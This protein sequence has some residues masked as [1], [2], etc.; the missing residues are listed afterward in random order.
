MIHQ[1]NANLQLDA[2][3]RELLASCQNMLQQHPCSTLEIWLEHEQNGYTASSILPGYRSISCHHQGLF[4][5]HTGHPRRLETIRFG[6]L[7][8]RDR[9]QVQY[10]AIRQP[11]CDYLEVSHV[12]RIPWPSTLIADYRYDL[13]PNMY[14]LQA[15]QVVDNPPV[16]CMLAG[17]LQHLRSLLLDAGD[18]YYEQIDRD[19]CQL[20]EHYP[21]I[22]PLW[23]S[24]PQYH[25]QRQR[26][27]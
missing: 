5:D 7:A 12:T 24:R 10:M 9:C 27:C 2:Y 8:A 20:G 11:L 26:V 15:W 23:Q 17:M 3:I 4:T 22:K 25:E 1:A 16:S 14:C 21:L 13:I 6:T 19:L 18:E